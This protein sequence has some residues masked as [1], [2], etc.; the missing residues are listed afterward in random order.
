MKSSILSC[1]NKWLNHLQMYSFRNFNRYSK[2]QSNLVHFLATWEI[3]QTITTDFYDAVDVHYA[4]RANI[5]K[6]F[7]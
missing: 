1:S 5:T 7:S 6:I 4:I 3:R 2:F